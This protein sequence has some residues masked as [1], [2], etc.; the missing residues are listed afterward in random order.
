MPAANFHPVVV[1]AVLQ[2]ICTEHGP[3]HCHINDLRPKYE[4]S[5][6]IM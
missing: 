4:K 6:R 1:K 3:A 5:I 2:S